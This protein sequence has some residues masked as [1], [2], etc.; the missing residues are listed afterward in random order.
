MIEGSSTSSSSQQS[1]QKPWDR[2]FACPLCGKT[3]AW[4]VSLT[5]HLREECGKLPQHVC[6]YCGKRFKQ[7][8]SYQRH[9]LTQHQC[10]AR[11]YGCG[12]RVSDL[13]SQKGP[14]PF[15]L[16]GGDYYKRVGRHVCPSCGKEY[17]W[18]QS[19]VRHKREECGKE[20]QHCCYICGQ[21]IRHKWKL[22]RHLLEV[23]RVVYMN[24]G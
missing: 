13:K 2:P 21:L 16:A 18:L 4:K 19:L 9:M 8:S 20:P 17:R 24:S 14:Y 6:A 1:T 7:R 23:H 5:R 10:E 3:Y 15:V 22:K 12:R 11:I